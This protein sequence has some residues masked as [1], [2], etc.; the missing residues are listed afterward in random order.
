MTRIKLEINNVTK[1]PLRDSFL[2]LITRKT[3]EKSGSDFLKKKNISLSVA[4]VGKKEIRKINRKYRRKNQ[5]T[6]ILSFP[7]YRGAR[8]M[9][10]AKE[11]DLFLG[12]LIICYDDIK[13]YAQK[14][15][16]AVKKELANVVS[17]GM[18]H[19]LGFGH[20]KRMF[21]IQKEISDKINGKQ[22]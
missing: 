5:V 22:K 15:G 17:H 9:K 3:I 10:A 19:L 1:S 16:I 18:L 8:Q 11:R 14:Q 13:D 7:E 20:G 12:E 6:D 4:I 21:G 2:R